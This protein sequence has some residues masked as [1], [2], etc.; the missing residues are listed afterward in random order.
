MNRKAVVQ[1]LV[2]R[3][4]NRWRAIFSIAGMIPM[5]VTALGTRSALG[6]LPA[7]FGQTIAA[8]TSHTA[9]LRSDGTVWTFGSNIY[10]ALG[11]NALVSPDPNPVPGFVPGLTGVTAIVAGSDHTVAL[12]SDGTVWTFG[13]NAAGQLGSVTLPVSVQDQVA[14]QVPGL[15]SVTAIAAGAY[16]TLALRSDG[17]VWSFGDNRSGDLG[18]T[19]GSSGYNPNAAPVPGLTGVTALA[20]GY[21]HTVLLRSDGTVWA[22]G[23]NR[24]G[25]LGWATTP[26]FS[27]GLVPTRVSGLRD[28]TAIAA[29]G[30]RTAV[31]RSDG[32][33][34]TFGL[35]SYG[36][37]GR[38]TA[39]LFQDQFPAQVPG[40]TNVTA[41]AAGAE[42]TLALRAD[43]TV[44]SSGGIGAGSWGTPP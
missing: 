26:A 33:V 34:W 23:D 36:E 8:G 19:T 35:N 18:R 41:I 5:L 37:L 1:Q 7:D 4:G 12:R 27:P 29:G 20:A 21:Y 24:S 40:L 17:T 14:A 31:L 13:L 38:I 25:Q 22:F 16:H 44:W 9:V 43:A 2:Y 28:V 30:Y 10:A 32:T 6:V 3:T 39:P 42:H 11:R 15:T